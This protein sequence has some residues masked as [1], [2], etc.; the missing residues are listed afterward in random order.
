MQK[1]VNSFFKVLL[2]NALLPDPI[3]VF[4]ERRQQ[5]SFSVAIGNVEFK[6]EFFI[7]TGACQQE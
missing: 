7:N 5:V 1:F 2:N 6:Q 4:A 3:A